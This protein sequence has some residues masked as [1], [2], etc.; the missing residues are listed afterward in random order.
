MT[1]TKKK[2]RAKKNPRRGLHKVKHKKR[3]TK[4]TEQGQMGQDDIFD[5][6][7][8][9]TGALFVDSPEEVQ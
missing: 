9:K 2:T 3:K 8:G 1:K 6:R 4:K 5:S 7:L